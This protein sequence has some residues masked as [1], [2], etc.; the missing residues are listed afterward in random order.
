MKQQSLSPK[1]Q[2]Q[3]AVEALLI[4]VLGFTLVLCIHHIGQLRSQTLYLL[5]E[6]YFLSLIPTRAQREVDVMSV[7]PLSERYAAVA[8]PSQPYSAQHRKLEKQLGFDSATLLRAS[9]VSAETLPSKLLT[10]RLAKQTPMVRHSYLLLGDG[11]AHSTQAAQAQIEG[12]ATLWHDNF[13]VSK[14]ITSA[15]SQ[16][17][18]SI[19]QAWGRAPP[20]TAWLLPWADEVL[21]PELLRPTSMLEQVKTVSQSPLN[22]S[23]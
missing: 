16:A 6:S 22:L 18:R 17:L 14:K 23:K 12:S 19:D 11:Q 9:A 7:T 21:A 2:G 20:N 3:A 4:M 15:S 1:D 13:A 8:L 5:G 10:P